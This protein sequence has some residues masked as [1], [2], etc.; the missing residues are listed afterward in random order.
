MS[1]MMIAGA[2]GPFIGLYA[3]YLLDKRASG[4]KYR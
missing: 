3:L 4:G 1:L 2:V